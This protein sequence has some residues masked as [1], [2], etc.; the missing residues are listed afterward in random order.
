[1]KLITLAF[2]VSTLLNTR[3]TKKNNLID[4]KM[5]VVPDFQT[6]N[7]CPF[8]TRVDLAWWTAVYR[9]WLWRDS[10]L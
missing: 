8:V 2:Y 7:V 1:M 6:N 3:K 10:F 5:F 9:Q 4:L